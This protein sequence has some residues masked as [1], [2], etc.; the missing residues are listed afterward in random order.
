MAAF[1]MVAA[2]CLVAAPAQRLKPA[3]VAARR[4]S[5]AADVRRNQT[6][7]SVHVWVR[8]AAAS[9]EQIIVA[10]PARQIAVPAQRL[11]PAAVAVQRMFAVHPASRPLARL[12]APN[13]AALMTVVGARLAAVLV[14]RRKLAA[15]SHPMFVMSSVVSMIRALRL[16]VR[17]RAAAE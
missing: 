17:N 1:P 4:T 10:L 14:R 15:L 6:L 13:A 3:A 2:A 11:K 16:A 8:I 12:K 7:L 5:V 9:P